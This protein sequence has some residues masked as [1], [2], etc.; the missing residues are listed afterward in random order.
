MEGALVD[1]ASN[2]LPS[3]LRTFLLGPGGHSL[4]IRGNAGT[5]KT[6]LALQLIEELAEIENSYYF[7]TR[8]SDSILFSQFPWLAKRLY[9]DEVAQSIVSEVESYQ[10]EQAD[11]PPE[12]DRAA[13]LEDET[14]R[15]WLHKLK[16]RGVFGFEIRP[17]QSFPQN[18]I[19]LSEMEKVYA[20]IERTGKGKSLVV[21]DSVDALA[22]SCG[23]NP[24]TVITS[25]QKDLVEGKRINMIFVAESNDRYL[26]YLGDGVVELTT[27][28]HH[29]RRLREMNI[30]KLRGCAIQQPKYLCT[31]SGAKLRTFS[32]HSF[33]S[34]TP[35]RGWQPI[36]DIMGKVSFGMADLD[37]LAQGGMSPGSIVL[38]ELG[39]GVPLH[40]TGLLEQVIVANFVSHRRG[41]LWVP[42]KKENTESSRGRMSAFVAKESFDRF[43]RVAE[44]ASEVQDPNLPCVMRIEGTNA[45]L[46]F[47]WKTVAYAMKDTSMPLLSLMGFDTLESI[48]GSKIMDQLTDHFAAVKR[49]KSLFVAMVSP[50]SKSTDRLVDLATCHLKVDRI[51]G[52]VIVYGVEPFTECNALA[53][54]EEN[55]RTRLELV[56]II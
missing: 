7:S 44:V 2:N 15:L 4:I 54:T 27:L 18:R 34:A 33:S 16:L 23:V 10:Q 3:E 31:L 21:I 46:D 39:Y 51:G 48:Y 36:M 38:I 56:P 9:G 8:V 26:D 6:T 32:D 12:A 13:P 35:I 14:R 40:V 19:D 17:G 49:H 30:L 11:A 50:S 24:A 29:R 37:R 22:E 20:A 5:G 52:T 43:V 25:I 45:Q 53:V 28:D 41:V 47:S 55:D 42:L 1:V